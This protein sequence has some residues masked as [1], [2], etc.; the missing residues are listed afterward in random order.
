[1]TE[2]S[3]KYLAENQFLQLSREVYLPYQEIK[4]AAIN[5]ASWLMMLNSM[6]PSEEL[7]QAIRDL[8]KDF[9]P[10][11]ITSHEQCIN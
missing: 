8:G 1:M 10:D 5:A 4:Y 11:L 2:D 9:D 6:S 3:E 7:E